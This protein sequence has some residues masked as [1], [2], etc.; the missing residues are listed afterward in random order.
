MGP[1]FPGN[2][3]GALRSIGELVSQT[4][5][6]CNVDDARHPVC[7]C[8]LDQL[9]MRWSIVLSECIDWFAFGIA[10]TLSIRLAKTIVNVPV[11][12]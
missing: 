3:V 6:G 10:F 5:F 9:R 12:Q 1:C 11:T 7:M 8:H 2:F 4:K